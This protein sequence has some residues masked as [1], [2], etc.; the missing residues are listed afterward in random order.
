MDEYRRR[1]GGE[2]E[3]KRVDW[4]RSGEQERR[5][6][7]WCGGRRETKER[8]AAREEEQKRKKRKRL[9]VSWEVPGGDRCCTS[10]STR[11]VAN[12]MDAFAR[13]SSSSSPSSSA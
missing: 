10:G 12:P 5:R 9:I 2:E 6:W 1:Y 3:G 11:R 4:G 13:S 7:W 8:K